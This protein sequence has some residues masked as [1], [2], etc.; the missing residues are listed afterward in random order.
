MLIPSG[1]TDPSAKPQRATSF[2]LYAK[3]FTV[4]DFIGPLCSVS[5][6]E[7]WALSQK[8]GKTGSKKVEVHANNKAS[9]TSNSNSNSLSNMHTAFIMG[10]K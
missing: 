1:K 3:E 7:Y 8:K 5:Y 6:K 4:A 10:G 2:T 9:S